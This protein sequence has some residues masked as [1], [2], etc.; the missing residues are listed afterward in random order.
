MFEFEWRNKKNYEISVYVVESVD[1]RRPS[2]LH[3]SRSTAGRPTWQNEK[4]NWFFFSFLFPL[5]LY[6]ENKSLKKKNCSLSSVF[7]IFPFS[8][9]ATLYI[10][11]RAYYNTMTSRDLNSFVFSKY[12][13]AVDT[14]GVYYVIRIESRRAMDDCNA[15]GAWLMDNVLRWQRRRR[16][17]RRRVR[18]I[19]YYMYK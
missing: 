2:S 6:V 5:R 15:A 1:R 14:A 11:A 19:M 17:R 4:K 9:R 10:I 8:P 3:A 7:M 16:R 18:T 12:R 13:A